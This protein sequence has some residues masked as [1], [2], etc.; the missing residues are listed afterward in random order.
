MIRTQFFI[1]KK[2]VAVCVFLLC[3]VMGSVAYALEYPKRCY[4]DEELAKVREWEKALSLI[5]I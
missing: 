2:A 3:F 5:H 4:T 1:E